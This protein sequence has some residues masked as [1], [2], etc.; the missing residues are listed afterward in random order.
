MVNAGSIEANLEAARNG[1]ASAFNWLQNRLQPQV[2][3]FAGRL[4]K[5][6]AMADDATQGAFLSLYVNMGSIRSPGSVKTY[7]YR[8]TRNL[9]YDELR[10]RGR[11]EHV[12]YDETMEV[13]PFPTNNS[14]TDLPDEVVASLRLYEKVG[15]AIDKLPE[16]QRQTMILY[17]HEDLRYR[18][19]ADV[20]SIDIGTVKSRI[21]LARKRLRIILGPE[22]LDEMGLT[23]DTRH[24]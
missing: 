20:L 5:D 1:D 3:R 18:E 12:T 16:Q 4:L 7:L 24:L 2:A 6:T 23:P 8:I 11:F 15:E 17:F 22:F 9:C 10:R 13:P 14:G 21:H 19:I